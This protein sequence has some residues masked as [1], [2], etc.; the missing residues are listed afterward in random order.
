MK[1]LLDV[2]DA[3]A[4]FIMELLN[5]FTYVKAKTISPQKAKLISEIRE[6]V[7]NLNLVEQGKMK[8]QSLSELLDEL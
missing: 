7:E 3:K 4:A 1:I 6:A 8:P 2:K 5:S